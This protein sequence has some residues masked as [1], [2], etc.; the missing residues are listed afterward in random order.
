MSLSAGLFE[1]AEAIARQLAELY[2]EADDAMILALDLLPHAPGAEALITQRLA[3]PGR[4]A[5]RQAYARALVRMQRAADAAR[6]YRELTQ[7]DP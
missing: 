3:Q 6:E 5:L 4:N 2:P 7:R 1:R